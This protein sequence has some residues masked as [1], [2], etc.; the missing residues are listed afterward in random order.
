M[1]EKWDLVLQGDDGY[2]ILYVAIVQ[3]DSFHRK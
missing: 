3:S 1:G 2:Q